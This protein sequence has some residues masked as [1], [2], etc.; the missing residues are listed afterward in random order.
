MHVLVCM[1]CSGMYSCVFASIC[2]YYVLICIRLYLLVLHVFVCIACMCMYLYWCVLM[3]ICMYDQYWH[4]LV[5]LVF[6][7]SIGVY[8]MY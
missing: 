4:V 6:I 3:C 7:A 8:G 2:M 1:V 5:V